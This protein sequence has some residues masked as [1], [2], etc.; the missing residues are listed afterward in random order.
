MGREASPEKQMMLPTVEYFIYV[1]FT[2]IV[3]GV[4]KN[5]LWESS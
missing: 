1:L 3:C 5:Y 4:I 2:F